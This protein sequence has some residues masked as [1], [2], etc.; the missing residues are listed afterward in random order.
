[1]GYIEKNTSRFTELTIKNEDEEEND[2]DQESLVFNL[3]EKINKKKCYEKKKE[4]SDYHLYYRR[5][6]SYRH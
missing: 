1:M 6:S 2:N 4:K 5:G 3:K